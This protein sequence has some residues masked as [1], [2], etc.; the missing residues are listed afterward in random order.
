MWRWHLRQV[1]RFHDIKHMK[2]VPFR[3]TPPPV[4]LCVD[5]DAPALQLRR[6]VLEQAG[7]A[8]YSAATA[9]EAMRIVRAQNL[10]LVLTDYYLD[11]VTGGELARAVKNEHPQLK[12]AIYSGALDLPDDARYAD[13]IITKA[14]G[15]PALISE[16]RA[17]IKRRQTAA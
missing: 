4:V 16:I 6:L 12:V 5:D 9:S 7:F 8:V 3:H 13:L 1:T 14:D 15:A 11:G 17:L 2:V 10:D